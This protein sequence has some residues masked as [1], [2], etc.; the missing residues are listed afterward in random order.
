M[1]LD[2]KDELV[3]PILY[4]KTVEG[5]QCFYDSCRKIHN[6]IRAIKEHCRVNHGW[7]AKDGEKWAGTRAQT[8]YQGNNQQ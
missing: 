5:F 7:K 3:N 4:L 1:E 8:F 2:H 6:T